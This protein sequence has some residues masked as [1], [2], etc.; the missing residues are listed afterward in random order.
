MNAV[1]HMKQISI[2]SNIKW[3]D[4][5]P[6]EWKRT[7]RS[8]EGVWFHKSGLVGAHMPLW[9]GAGNTWPQ[10][11]GGHA[12]STCCNG[13]VTRGTTLHFRAEKPLVC[14]S[15]ISQDAV[16]PWRPNKCLWL[17]Q[18]SE[19]A[20]RRDTNR[21]NCVYISSESKHGAP[22]LQP[23]ASRWRCKEIERCLVPCAPIRWANRRGELRWA[24]RYEIFLLSLLLRS[25]RMF[26]GVNSRSLQDKVLVPR[27]SSPV[28]MYVELPCIIEQGMRTSDSRTELQA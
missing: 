2:D 27:S 26:S 23:E 13:A 24:K 7:G 18:N 14:T 15:L 8:D 20:A 28:A 21:E 16:A 25:A 11:E 17:G 3:V 9:Q 12:R 10:A 1:G 4:W 6:K 22:V 5:P 19:A